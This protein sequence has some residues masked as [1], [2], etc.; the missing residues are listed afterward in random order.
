MSIVILW[1]YCHRVGANSHSVAVIAT[2]YPV[3]IATANLEAFRM[4]GRLLQKKYSAKSEEA[5]RIIGRS[6]PICSEAAPQT[7]VWKNIPKHGVIFKDMYRRDGTVKN[8]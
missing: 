7:E 2:G 3:A 6:L 4:F 8:R 5:F 1:L